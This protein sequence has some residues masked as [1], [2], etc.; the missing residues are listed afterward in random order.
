MVLAQIYSG[1]EQYPAA[2]ESY[3][4]AITIRPDRADLHEARAGLEERLMRFDDAATD[5]ERLYPLAF[6][7]PKWMEKV[8]EVR[9]RQGKAG[10]VVAALKAALIEGTPETAGKY[11]E[12]AR[13]LESWGLLT[14][15]CSFAE[16]GIATS[17]ADL[18]ATAQQR[19][20]A[21]LYARIMTR[22]RQQEKAYATLQS[23]LND[24]S[25]ALPVIKEQ[26]VREGIAAITD[27]EWRER[28][29][30]NRVRTARE[31]MRAALSEIGNTVATYF[32]PEERVTFAA[33]AE[34]K[35]A[36]M[37]LA[38]VDAFAIPLAQSAGLADLEARWRYELMMQGETNSG[39]GLARMRSFVELQRRRLKFADLG[40]QLEQF[41]PRIE[42]LQ[43]YSVWIAAADSYR[44]A[45]DVEN[46]LRVLA[47]IPPV[48]VNGDEQ[49][50]L[51]QLLLTR[52]PQELVQRGS[53]WNAWGQ[54]AANYVVANGDAALAHAL[55]SSRSRTR[56]PVWSKSY[57]S[58]V[59]LYF[60]EPTPQVNGAFLGALG[61]NTIAERLAKPVDRS[62]QLA[63]SVWFYYG[64]RYGE[65]RGVTKQGDPEEFL[66]AMLEQSPASSSGYLSVADYYVDNGNTA[67]AI[68]DY[69]HA[70]ELAP[71]QADIHDR[72]ALAYYKQDGRAEAIMQ[73]KR[74]L[75]ALQ[76]QVSKGQASESFWTDF[77]HLCDHLRT[78][79]VFS[80]L[81]SEVDALLRAYL[82]RNGNYRSNTLL[83]SAYVAI[84]DPVAAT[85]W[86][87]DLSSV[88]P[89]PTAVLADVVE[90]PWIS[91][92]QR[93]PIYQRVLELKQD[94][95]T[96]QE[97]LEKE[98][99]EQT[100]RSWQVRWTKYL[101]LTKQYPAAG[102]A[103]ASLPKQTREA[104]AMALVPLELQVAAQTGSL[105]STIAGYR[106]DPL[107]APASEVLRTAARQLFEAGDK[108]SARKLLE[109][110]FA[111]ELDE[112]K[113]VAAN[114]L[115]L[116]EIRIAAGDTE[117]AVKLLRR[118]VV[119]VGNPFENLEPAAVLLEKTGRNAEAV[120]FLGQLAQSAP[121]K[122]VYRLRLAKAIIAAGKDTGPAQDVVVSIASSPDVPYTVRT[123]AALTLTGLHHQS[124]QSQIEVGS[125]ELSLLASGV[126]GSSAFAADQP[127]FYEAR[128]QAAQSS[129]EPRIKFRLLR[130]AL[131]DTPTRDDAR[132]P[133]FL[134]A[135]RERSDQ[136]ARGVIEPLLH[137]QFL[138]RVALAPIAED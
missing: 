1:L 9:A 136:F 105:D 46:E 19:L 62:Q 60:A 85:V 98:G 79:R 42:P 125:K 4:K 43:R 32:T 108:Q 93:A 31:G 80:D 66:P 34:S 59:G 16:Q 28:T 41:A 38:D 7:D 26:L 29:Q 44:S 58:L 91:V 123:Q 12:V 88:A 137:Q 112:H 22:L 18:L 71:G 5:Y 47:A 33:F 14:Q 116:A 138:S 54:E 114:F 69:Q 92:A 56:T 21:S 76:Q 50:R 121:W 130:N 3:S 132:I 103:I 6:K 97:G 8:A 110:V 49:G 95:L 2:I 113:L 117:G 65:Y 74:A 36:A 122:P 120:E 64:S 106:S 40:S 101:V 53:Y 51:F 73:W 55:V 77:A 61:D 107:S 57:D 17:G 52:R 133:L 84:G 39:V 75:G 11:F 70:L 119:A 96:K 131:A 68:A 67:Q 10:D 100:L 20:D 109:F 86:L 83:H 15:V 45:G 81:K 37:N 124:D 90:A 94:A 87:L 23:V 134:A 48:Y 30:E 129:S 78:R 135:A 126:N 89:D 127:F 104:E 13:R 99:S 24:A 27:R 35:R 102:A 111:R 115:G 25:S 63:G 72:L 82:R 118:L 128:L